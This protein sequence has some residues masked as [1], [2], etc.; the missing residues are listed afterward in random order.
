MFNSYAD[1]KIITSMEID[2]RE[3]VGCAMWRIAMSHHY[4]WG[5]FRDKTY[6]TRVENGARKFQFIF[7]EGTESWR[8]WQ[9]VRGFS[10]KLPCLTLSVKALFLVGNFPEDS[11]IRAW[12]LYQVW[13]AEGFLPMD[14]KQIVEAESIMD[15]AE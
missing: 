5:T 8:I 7:E 11:N 3:G 4:T 15:I 14:S 2:A 13:A 12:N 10:F 6:T 1:F 9:S